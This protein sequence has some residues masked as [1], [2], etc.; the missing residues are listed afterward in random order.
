MSCL[1][2]ATFQGKIHDMPVASRVSRQKSWKER[3]KTPSLLHEMAVTHERV[4]EQLLALRQLHGTP[5]R[6]LSQEKAAQRAGVSTR[7]WQR[8]ETKETLPRTDSLGRVADGFDIPLD[9][10]DN[11]DQPG[12]TSTPL[13]DRLDTIE[14]MLALLLEAQGI[15]FEIAG[16]GEGPLLSG[17]SDDP[18]SRKAAKPKRARR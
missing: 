9:T 6:P 17:P 15:T 3:G 18:T 16:P 12:R 5:D 7:D 14:Q 2:V 13:A 1:H 4:A 10:F 8:W 11:G